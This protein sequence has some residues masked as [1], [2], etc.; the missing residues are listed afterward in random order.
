MLTDGF[1]PPLVRDGTTEAVLR[2]ILVHTEFRIRILTKNVVVGS[3]RWVRLFA[4]HPGRFVVGLSAGTD[5]DQWARA[6]EI[7][8]PSPSSR[9]RALGHLQDAGVPTYGMLCPV[10]PGMLEGDRLERL[11]DRVHPSVV[12]HVWAEPFN[13]RTNWRA[14][15]AGYEPS[16]AGYRWLTEV[17]SE[18]DKAK[19]SAYATE[20]YARLRAKAEHEGWLEKLRY[21]LYEGDITAEDAPVFA[22]LKGVLL[23][24]KPDTDG[25]SKNRYIAE[26]ARHASGGP[27]HHSSAATRRM[28]GG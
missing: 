7:G 14:V 13:D 5:D 19:W 26:V 16:S 4:E 18:G 24:S 17:Y 25:R 15:Q 21:L 12:E 3:P 8:T 28:G 2:L 20:L 9:L 22:D 23:Q 6:V 10:F 11:V 1:S 27:V